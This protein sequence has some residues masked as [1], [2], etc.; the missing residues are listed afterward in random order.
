MGFDGGLG[1][2]DYGKGGGI[3]LLWKANVDINILN[4]SK[5]YIHTYIY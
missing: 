3:A 1:V 4:F 5:C 2:E